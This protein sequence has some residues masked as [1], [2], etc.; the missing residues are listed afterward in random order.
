[1]DAAKQRMLVRVAAYISPIGRSLGILMLL[2]GGLLAIL[3]D[4][5]QSFTFRLLEPVLFLLI[6]A[7]LL[8]GATVLVLTLF[9]RCSACGH[10]WTIYAL[11]KPEHGRD[12]VPEL[13]AREQALAFVWP[14]TAYISNLRCNKCGQAFLSSANAARRSPNP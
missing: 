10:R 5:R 14:T 8:I 2:L 4:D 13:T 3:Q 9:I 6:G 1:M 7:V 12:K 11:V